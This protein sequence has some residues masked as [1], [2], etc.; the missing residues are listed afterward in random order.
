M[1]RNVTRTLLSSFKWSGYF[2]DT[3]LS[4]RVTM[5]DA[6]SP[7]GFDNSSVTFETGWRN[8]RFQN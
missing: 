6:T 3:C 7:G 2:I 5:I 4:E 1:Q 8:D